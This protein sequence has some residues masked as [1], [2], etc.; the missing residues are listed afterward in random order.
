MS[1]KSTRTIYLVIEIAQRERHAL[2]YIARSLMDRG[3]FTH[4]YIVELR[5]FLQMAR[6]RQLV[7]GVVLLKS[8]PGYISPILKRLKNAGFA[9]CVQNQ[10]GLAMLPS[11]V[12]SGWQL[13]KK[14]IE[15]VDYVFSAG[16]EEFNKLR[17]QIP[18]E[19]LLRSETIRLQLPNKELE[20]GFKGE[21][22]DIKCSHGE[23]IVF[24]V[25]TMGDFC[26]GADFIDRLEYATRSSE[27]LADTASTLAH[28]YHIWAKSQQ[29]TLY[30]LCDLVLQ[31][32]E[33]EEI[34]VIR[35]HPS[36]NVNFLRYLF[37]G[38]ENV[39]VSTC[40][41]ITPWLLSSKA[42]ICSTSTVA[43][44]ASALGIRPICLVPE[45]GSEGEFLKDIA[46]N[47][48]GSLARKASDVI[49]ILN[50]SSIAVPRKANEESKQ[51]I[52][53]DFLT[54]L[55]SVSFVS[56]T[57]HT[58]MRLLLI[59]VGTL[60]KLKKFFR[61]QFERYYSQ[62][63]PGFRTIYSTEVLKTLK[64][65]CDRAVAYETLDEKSR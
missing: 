19:K 15:Y 38:L 2:E 60:L 43:M 40:Y 65:Y 14:S 45:I 34:L 64:W 57:R 3:G 36:D 4:I 46:V 9:I 50:A 54:T 63:F 20:E 47:R 48:L 8:A 62:K 30:S 24:F 61:P 44:E 13:N 26:H 17:N 53:C 11:E 28:E 18:D 59:V 33:R 49:Q 25:S 31:F 55:E 52:V 32:R 37:R 51:K 29:H 58:R 1:K 35:P 5:A 27:L 22:A 16:D 21:I 6:L 7:P 42:V 23:N 39:R 56:R 12:I 41:S 10:E